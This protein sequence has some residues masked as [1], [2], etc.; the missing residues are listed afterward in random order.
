MKEETGIAEQLIDFLEEHPGEVFSA[1]E[2]TDCLAVV[3]DRLMDKLKKLIKHNEVE[4]E[5]VS[6]KVARKIYKDSK[7]K[8]GLNLYFLDI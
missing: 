6:C 3:Y 2:L 7:I 1:A 8:R 4:F 5:R